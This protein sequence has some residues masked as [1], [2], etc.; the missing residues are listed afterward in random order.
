M[1]DIVRTRGGGREERALRGPRG[2]P[3]A[4]GVLMTASCL[5]V[6]HF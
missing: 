4:N 5:S 6:T 1:E 3:L 2:E